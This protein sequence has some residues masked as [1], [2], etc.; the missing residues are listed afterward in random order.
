M[1][2]VFRA[3]LFLMLSVLPLGAIGCPSK[4]AGP[5]AAPPKADVAKPDGAKAEPGAGKP[6]DGALTTT[7][8]AF[9]TKVGTLRPQP[10]DQEK[11]PMSVIWIDPERAK[12]AQE[13][14][15]GWH[16]PSGSRIQGHSVKFLGRTSPAS[17]GW[18]YS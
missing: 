4:D 8:A 5:P 7:N 17:A 1:R 18:T 13:K 9:N 3:R 15:C 14:S 16:S 11:R 6:D 12:H 10:S 2:S